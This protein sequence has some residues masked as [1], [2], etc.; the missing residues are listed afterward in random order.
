MPTQFLCLPVTETQSRLA[1]AAQQQ[2]PHQDRGIRESKSGFEHVILHTNHRHKVTICLFC[3]FGVALPPDGQICLTCP[4][5]SALA[6]SP[7]AG[8]PKPMSFLPLRAKEYSPIQSHAQAHNLF[9]DGKHKERQ[10]ETDR[11]ARLGCATHCFTYFLA[12]IFLNVKR[13]LGMKKHKAEEGCRKSL[14][15]HTL[16][17]L[18]SLVQERQQDSLPTVCGLQQPTDIRLW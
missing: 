4:T 11:S 5:P 13:V 7:A 14:V 6:S 8:P 9:L 10:Q 1:W 15:M 12:P 2:T 16:C 18:D 17:P 3:H